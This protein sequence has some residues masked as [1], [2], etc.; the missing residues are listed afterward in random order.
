MTGITIPDLGIATKLCDVV[1]CKQIILAQKLMM[2][3]AELPSL[4]ISVQCT[5]ITQIVI[6]SMSYNLDEFHIGWKSMHQVQGSA[7]YTKIQKH[8]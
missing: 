2:Q 4:E 1:W 3:F 8:K 5:T 6:V 7:E